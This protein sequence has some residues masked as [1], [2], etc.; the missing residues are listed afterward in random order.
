MLQ[1]QPWKHGN[2][3]GGGNGNGRGSPA[4]SGS[5]SSRSSPVYVSVPTDDSASLDSKSGSS[6]SLLTNSHLLRRGCP[7]S[8]CDHVRDILC[9]YYKQLLLLVIFGVTGAVFLAFSRQYVFK[10]IEV[11]KNV[12]VALQCALFLGEITS[13]CCLVLENNGKK[14]LSNIATTDLKD[15]HQTASHFHRF[16]ISCTIFPFSVLRYLLVSADVGIHRASG[17]RRISSR[18]HQ[19]KRYRDRLR[20]RRRHHLPSSLVILS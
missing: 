17:Q 13:L 18:R 14:L 7:L 8:V 20:G 5:R 6:S 4:I 2:G 12:D 9:Q 10:A 16:I 3:G 15:Q 11:L 19:G 1:Q